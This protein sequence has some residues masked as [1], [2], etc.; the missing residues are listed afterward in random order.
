MGVFFDLPDALQ[1]AILSRWLRW[2]DF[3]RLDS[4]VVN[5]KQRSLFRN[6]VTQE[7]CTFCLPGRFE[8]CPSLIW[9][10]KR[11]VQI[12]EITIDI[13]ILSNTVHRKLILAH[14]G[15][16]IKAVHFRLGSTS[17][18]DSVEW[19][20]H[21][22]AALAEM[23]LHCL[24]LTTFTSASELPCMD[25]ITR[26]AINNYIKTCTTLEKI[27]I[28]LG[29]SD[30]STLLALCNA[31]NLRELT[32][33]NTQWSDEMHTDLKSYT[34]TS[35]KTYCNPPGAYKM[36][37][38]LTKLHVRGQ[39]LQDVDLLI[40][41]CAHLTEVFLDL[42]T[43]TVLPNTTIHALA[44]RWVNLTKLEL[45]G[46]SV[47]E[48]TVVLIITLCPTL[49]WLLTLSLEEDDI[50]LPSVTYPAHYIGSRLALLSIFC[51]DATTLQFVTTHCPYLHVL[52]LYRLRSV[53]HEDGYTPVETALHCIANTAITALC[54]YGLEGITSE[55]L[56][57]L[58]HCN[59]EYLAIDSVRYKLTTAAVLAL[60][61]TLKLKVLKISY[62]HGVYHDIV[63]KVP[64]ICP[65]LRTFEYIAQGGSES[66][67]EL[68]G[69]LLRKQFPRITRFFVKC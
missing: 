27:K 17:T 65:T 5:R 57:R 9:M 37:P 63:M 61:P 49:T 45:H 29:D 33:T 38:N 8:R 18:N 31:P 3:G 14:F 25:V 11:G 51:V 4:A 15:P 64:V 48:E 58:R 50:P 68:F 54:M 21:I 53:S 35:L 7:G 12:D 40:E 13:N 47:S 20:T 34:V 24:K 60:V 6:A 59:I 10:T 46:D 41:Q 16:K 55:I 66:C 36:F 32:I 69:E 62:C 23:R 52:Q 42:T 1:S 28:G 44:E 67:H 22:D 56:L 30:L 26:I 43:D 2:R 19:S 39:R